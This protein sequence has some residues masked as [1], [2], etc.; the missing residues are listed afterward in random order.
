[1]NDVLNG[2]GSNDLLDGQAGSD[3]YL[4]LAAAD[5]VAPEV[6]DTGPGTDSDEVRFAGTTAGETLRLYANDLGI[7]RIVIGTGTGAVAD[8]SGLTELSINA[9]LMGNAV[10]IVGND[11]INSIV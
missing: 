5:H 2:G 9:G 10:T 1:G 7:E 6:D 4:I 3:I 8:T 11:G